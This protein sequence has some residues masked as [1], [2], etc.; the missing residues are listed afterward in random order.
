M[1]K[2][3]SISFLLNDNN[4]NSLQVDGNTKEAFADFSDKG[5]AEEKRNYITVNDQSTI[6]S[7]LHK[8]S[9]IQ[10]LNGNKSLSRLSG[11]AESSKYDPNFKK[12]KELLND[13]KNTLWSNRSFVKHSSSKK[14]LAKSKGNTMRRSKIS[15][16]QLGESTHSGF[17]YPNLV[18]STS[19]RM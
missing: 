12:N 5:P 10:R 15:I 8:D 13:A 6:G 1:R 11:I 9:S 19:H 2:S 18:T 14:S 3:R 17:T 7:G 4:R 16:S